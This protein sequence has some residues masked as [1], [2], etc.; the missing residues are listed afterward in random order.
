MVPNQFPGFA[1]PTTQPVNHPGNAFPAHS[2]S[3]IN[4]N[5]V[6]AAD[7]V[8]STPRQNRRHPVIPT[9]NLSLELRG[10]RGDPKLQHYYCSPSPVL[11]LAKP[12]R[13]P[14]LNQVGRTSKYQTAGQ[15]SRI[16]KVMIRIQ[17]NRFRSQRVPIANN[18]I[19]KIG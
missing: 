14:S 12:P 2:S 16:R 11:L 13:N 7:F 5:A 9:G 3:T 10:F 19:I 4:A 8:I 17:R 6:T 15:M 1:R 18:E